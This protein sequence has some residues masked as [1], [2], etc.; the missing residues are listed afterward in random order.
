MDEFI[1]FTEFLACLPGEMLRQRFA[2]R[3]W[4]IDIKD[5]RT[6]VTEADRQAEQMIRNAISD[7]YPRHGIIAEEF[8][9]E[10][11]RAEWVWVVD[12]IDGTISFTAGVPLF[13]TLI[14]LLHRG[15]PVIGAIYQPVLDELC[16]GTPEETRLNGQPV[17]VRKNRPL[18]ESTLLVT[19]PLHVPLHQDPSGYDALCREVGLIRTWGDCYGY[20]MVATGRADIMLD[21]VMN[22]WD[23]MA[24]IPVI[25]GAGGTIT[26]WQGNPAH[27]ALSSVAAPPDLHNEVITLLNPSASP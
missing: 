4:S 7:T 23:I 13:G 20:L 17:R 14:A 2:D 3:D 22:M 21:P 8:G 5:D 1:E 19:D 26:S 12:P 18:S 9:S 24:V 11:D 15:I 25:Q 27:Q 16:I 6:I 10:Q